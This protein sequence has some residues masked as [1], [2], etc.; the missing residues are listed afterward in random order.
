MINFNKIDSIKINRTI[1][2][3]TT[4]A[5]QIAGREGCEVFVLWVG[6]LINIT[7]FKVSR[8]LIPEQTCYK[9]MWGVRVQIDSA[10]LHR[11]SREMYEGR[12]L[13]I[14]QVH[15]HPQEAYHSEADDDIPLVTAL[16]QFSL[17]VPYFGKNVRHD[18]SRIKVFRLLKAG[19]VEL[20]PQKVDT[21]FEV[22]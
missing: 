4:K 3:E 6:T 5:F 14:A 22:T 9:T 18:F 17:V 11:I 2:D 21:I 1:F 13:A 16:G 12:E 20:D 15:S 7:E 8:A 19:W 10:E